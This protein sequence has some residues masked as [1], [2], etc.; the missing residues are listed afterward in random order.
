MS[1]F[2]LL[3]RPLLDYKTC[4]RAFGCPRAGGRKHAGC[5]LY[6]PIG[7]DIIAIEDGIVQIAP[8]LFY[9][10]TYALEIK[11]PSGVVRYGEIKNGV[12]DLKAGTLV[13]Q[14]QV[15]AQVGQLIGMTVSMLHF[16]LYGGTVPGQLTN[17]NNPP[18]LRRSDLINPTEFL[19]NCTL[20]V[21]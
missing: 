7:T 10:G 16:E 13:K 20:F 12:G 8:Y 17:R 15:I 18:Y 11:H 5:D 6:A 19:D 2:P 14:G 4:P 9:S 21:L 3:K 1:V